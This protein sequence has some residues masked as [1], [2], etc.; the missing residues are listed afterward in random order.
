VLRQAAVVVVVAGG[1]FGKKRLR[2]LVDKP[3]EISHFVPLQKDAPVE[4]EYNK[5]GRLG[6][7]P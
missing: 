2:G 1:F 5:M 6:G 7:L 4:N 3:G